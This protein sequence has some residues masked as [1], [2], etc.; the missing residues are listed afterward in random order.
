M[1]VQRALELFNVTEHPRTVAGITRTLG[2]PLVC[3]RPHLAQ[4]SIVGIVVAWELSWYRYETDLA[5]ENGAV[6]VVEQGT[7]LDELEPA[8]REANV[9]ADELGALHLLSQAAPHA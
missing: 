6:R 5:D 2:A 4:P 1:K 3:A 8:D 7:E 9:A